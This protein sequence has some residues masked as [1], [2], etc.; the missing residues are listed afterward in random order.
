MNELHITWCK[1]VIIRLPSGLTRRFDGPYE[2]K[3]FLENE[4]PLRRGRHRDNASRQC[5]A[6]LKRIGSAE[7]A[8]EAFIAAAIEADCY[9]T[10]EIAAAA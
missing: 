8:R 5:E 2:A 1:P 3:D 10:G 9:D 7:I 4:W 6:A